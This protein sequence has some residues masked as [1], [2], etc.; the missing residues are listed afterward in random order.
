M[1]TTQKWLTGCGIGC[2]SMILILAGLVGGGTFLV[3]R[4]IREADSVGTTMDALRA[5]HG[6]VAGGLY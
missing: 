2:G 6:E 1:T 4:M 3:K 5:R